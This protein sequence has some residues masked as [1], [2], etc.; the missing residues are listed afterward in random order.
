MI[1]K[2]RGILAAVEYEMDLKEKE[3]LAR[4]F[5]AVTSSVDEKKK[6]EAKL[7][8]SLAG[9]QTLRLR[10]DN[11]RASEGETVEET[12]ST[13]TFGASGEVESWEGKL[14]APIAKF[15]AVSKHKAVARLI[16]GSPY[17]D[18]NAMRGWAHGGA[19]QV[20]RSWTDE[21]FR[22]SSLVD[23]HLAARPEHD[24]EKPG[25]YNASHAEKQLV[26]AFVSE[27]VFLEDEV[28]PISQKDKTTHHWLKI[29]RYIGFSFSEAEQTAMGVE[30][31][32]QKQYPLRTLSM[33]MPAASLTEAT[34]LV[35]N[36]ICDDCSEF[37]DLVNTK[38][39]LL[40][41][42]QEASI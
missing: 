42:L 9:L 11:P 12:L 2:T 24:Q 17:P 37:V 40:I 35:G 39:G 28:G 27:H 13:L 19:D 34:I 8:D 22:I 15:L 41:R 14:L 21:V 26:A 18:I 5:A 36:E 33:D 38:L 32:M 29:S 10:S 30:S 7:V 1:D 16:R 23:H 3:R 20:G 25:Q 31:H 4:N 6:N